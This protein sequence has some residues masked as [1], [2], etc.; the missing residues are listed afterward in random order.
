M[1]DEVLAADQKEAQVKDRGAMLLTVLTGS[2]AVLHFMYQ[3][4]QVM[5][6]AVRDTL[7]IGP[8]EVGAIVSTRHL[9]WGLSSLPGGMICDRLKRHFSTILALC[10]AAFALGWLIIA[11]APTYLIV[12]AGTVVL[13]IG[14]SIWHLPSAAVL[15]ERFASRRGTA[16][17]IHGVGGNLGDSIGPMIT[18]VALVYLSWRHVLSIYAV[19]PLL[20]AILALRAFRDFR[21]GGQELPTTF[22]VQDLFRVTGDVLRNGT[23][24]RIN[25]V[26]GLRVVCSE[27]YTTFLPL[28]LADDLGFDTR[29]IGF[30]FGLMFVVGIIASPL[31]GFVSDRLGRKAAL[32]PVL[33]GSGALSLLLSQYG[34]GLMLTVILGLLGLTLRSDYSLLSASA[35]D[36]AGAGAATTTLGVIAFI[37]Y[38][39]AAVSPLV[40][41]ALYQEFGMQIT[42][43][44]VAAGFALA[45]FIFGTTRLTPMRDRFS[46][47]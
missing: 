23:L 28:Y 45:A 31:A 16:L 19:V 10:M 34:R 30:H 12:I 20:A 9:V 35:L 24:W 47:G 5:L 39:T 2:H 37:Q 17:A 44:Y 1:A 3:S 13:A 7:G 43:R 41:G 26:S 29:G 4:F 42:L 38:V 15:S 32:V 18:G 46:E 22:K 33:L 11:A 27:V 14:A 36:V 21:V 8:L 40:A 25:I 6:P